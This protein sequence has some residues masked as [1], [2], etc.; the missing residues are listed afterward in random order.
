MNVRSKTFSAL[1]RRSDENL[2]AFL[3]TE[4][5]LGS[6]LARVAMTASEMGHRESCERSA[7]HAENTYSEVARFLAN[8]KYAK[9][10]TAEQ[11]RK[12]RFDMVR[13]RK[14]LDGLPAQHRETSHDRHY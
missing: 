2:L 5:A 12:I 14:A 1:Q 9:R 4:L 11:R 7:R 13:L 3:Q 6:T 10:I 8:P